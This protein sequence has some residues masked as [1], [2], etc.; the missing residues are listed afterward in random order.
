MWFKFEKDN[1]VGT[2]RIKNY[3]VA[4]YDMEH[5]GSCFDESFYKP[6]E[7][8]TV[9]TYVETVEDEGHCDRRRV[10]VHFDDGEKYELKLERIE[11]GRRCSKFNGW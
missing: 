10:F 4:W 7:I 1:S 2:P 9:I 6:E 5:G 8:G 3:Q 11:K